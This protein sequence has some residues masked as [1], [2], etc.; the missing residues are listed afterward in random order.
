MERCYI[1]GAQTKDGNNMCDDC[2]AKRRARLTIATVEHRNHSVRWGM[3][4]TC[5]ALVVTAL[6]VNRETIQA[7]IDPKPATAATP[8][9]TAV[10]EAP[11]KEEVV[12]DVSSM[13]TQEEMMQWF[14][15][16]EKPPAPPPE[17]AA[18]FESSKPAVVVPRRRSQAEPETAKPSVTLT[19]I[20]PRRALT[21]QASEAPV[22]TPP[23]PPTVND[24]VADDDGDN[25]NVGMSRIARRRKKAALNNAQ[26]PIHDSDQYKHDWYIYNRMKRHAM[27]AQQNQSEKTQN[28]RD[29][30]R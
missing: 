22:V 17:V 2:S 1:C 20:A 10:K 29:K 26:A 27:R 5:A 4:L 28:I 19:A 13:P 21:S 15:P 24:E 6:I 16:T 30:I 14:G 12:Q 11:V 23:E 25:M 18:E 8:E 3:W 7:W 9:V